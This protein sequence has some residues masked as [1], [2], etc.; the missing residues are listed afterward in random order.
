MGMSASNM[1]ILCLVGAKK[2]EFRYYGI[3]IAFV[4]MHEI[5]G[6]IVLP[7]MR[8]NDVSYF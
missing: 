7:T 5:L 6:N 2:E 3:F 1:A 4:Q 8:W